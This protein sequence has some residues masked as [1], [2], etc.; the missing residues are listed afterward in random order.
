MWWKRRAVVRLTFWLQSSRCALLHDTITVVLRVSFALRVSRVLEDRSACHK[1]VDMK[2]EQH[3]QGGDQNALLCFH[4]STGTPC[5]GS[6]SVRTMKDMICSSSRCLA[7]AC[8]FH[9]DVD[10]KTYM[11]QGNFCPCGDH[12]GLSNYRSFWGPSITGFNGFARCVDFEEIERVSD[13][14][15][16]FVRFC[17][18][19]TRNLTISHSPV[20]P[21]CWTSSWTR[22][23]HYRVEASFRIPSWSVSKLSIVRNRRNVS[24]SRLCRDRNH[25]A[26]T[27]RHGENVRGLTRSMRS[28]SIEV[29]GAGAAN[30]IRGQRSCCWSRD[31]TLK[32]T[33]ERKCLAG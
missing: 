29:R 23:W 22:S 12:S 15:A 16:V 7:G 13:T 27:A 25:D 8:T 26:W 14:K 24:S 1:E 17:G 21:Q 19:R 9:I 3:L 4:I 10:Q 18:S 30:G 6:K 28:K 33:S 31:K 20:D 5:R 11:L 2:Y 32:L